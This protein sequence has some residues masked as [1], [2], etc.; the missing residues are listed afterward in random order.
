MVPADSDME[1]LNS[2]SVQLI[3]FGSTVDRLLCKAIRQPVPPT[4]RVASR[5]PPT[6]LAQ[7]RASLAAGMEIPFAFTEAEVTLVGLNT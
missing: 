3:P 4:K 7:A 6:C 5:L 1:S 2:S